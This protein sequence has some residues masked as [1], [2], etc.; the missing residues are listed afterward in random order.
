VSYAPLRCRGSVIYVRIDGMSLHAMLGGHLTFQGVPGAGN[1]S[2]S[3]GWFAELT[4]ADFV[5]AEFS[6]DAL[7]AEIVT[8]A[9]LELIADFHACK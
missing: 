3:C 9:K 2:A 7:R 6:P 1:S 5:P 8:D 4:P